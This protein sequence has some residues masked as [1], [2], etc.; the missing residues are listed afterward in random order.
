[1][2]STNPK[3]NKEGTQRVGG[4]KTGFRGPVPLGGTAQACRGAGATGVP[5]ANP[6]GKG[7][8]EAGEAGGSVDP[9]GAC[10][11][12]STSWAGLAESRV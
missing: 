10:S 6:R 1:M 7:G 11:F 5:E 9:S 12:L 8:Q 2:S 3:Q 4:Q